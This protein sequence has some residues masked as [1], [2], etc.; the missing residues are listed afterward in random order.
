MLDATACPAGVPCQADETCNIRSTA[1]FRMA[2]DDAKE[3]RTN[4][5]P[6]G[7]NAA[8][9]IA[10]T[11]ASSSMMRQISSALRP[12]SETSTQA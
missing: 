6:A 5:A 3:K 12:A 2:V 8:P 1:S 10:A 11:P 7:P 4:S 9:G